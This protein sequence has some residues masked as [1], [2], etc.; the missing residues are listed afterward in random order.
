MPTIVF[1]SHYMDEVEQIC[2][3]IMIIDKGRE[4]ATGSKKD[5]LKTMIS[6][7]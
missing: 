3:R 6:L 5:E 4:I 2:S 1:T 7:G